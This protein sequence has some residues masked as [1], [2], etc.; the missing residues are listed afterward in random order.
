MPC[1][2]E[3]GI[4]PKARAPLTPH[5][6][7]AADLIRWRHTPQLIRV[8]RQQNALT[9]KSM[10][11]SEYT[12]RSFQPPHCMS[13]IHVFLPFTTIAQKY[14]CAACAP[15]TRANMCWLPL[16]ITPLLRF[17]R[18]YVNPAAAVA[19]TPGAGWQLLSPS[20]RPHRAALLSRHQLRPGPSLSLSLH[21]HSPL[22]TTTSII[23][24]LSLSFV[25]WLSSPAAV[26]G[27]NWASLPAWR[28]PHTP[29][30]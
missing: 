10:I 21:M 9:S 30:L 16:A 26:P 25:L 1:A 29:S 14:C 17:H 15:D 8:H 18:F 28:T 3:A 5:Y 24:S 2:S 12:W 22:C 23:F 13:L 11:C 19:P 6:R 4:D 27:P 20:T 7:A